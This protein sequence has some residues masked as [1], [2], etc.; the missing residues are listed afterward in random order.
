[1]KQ[2]L[3]LCV[4]AIFAVLAGIATQKHF[5]AVDSG[6][7][8]FSF[9]DLQGKP[10][11]S[12]EW[13]GKLRLI[14]FWASW[15]PPCLKEIPE[16]IELQQQLGQENIQFIGI[17]IED[18]QSALSYSAIDKINYPVLIGGD[19]AI[20]LAQKLGNHINAVPYSIIVDRHNNIVHRQPGEFSKQEILAIVTPLIAAEK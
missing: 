15:C 1:M 9:L 4:A 10:R 12:E 16:F 11:S 14:N 13:H 7:L 3:I 2:S 5:T 20:T 8:E 17:A 19:Q 18:R 6:M